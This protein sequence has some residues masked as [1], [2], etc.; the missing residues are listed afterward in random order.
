[1]IGMKY[2][3]VIRGRNFATNSEGEG[4]FEWVRGAYMQHRGTS[5]TPRFKAAD[6]FRRYVLEM[7]RDAHRAGGKRTAKRSANRAGKLKRYRIVSSDGIDLGIYRASS[8][9]AALDAMARRA[10]YR[11]Q[12]EAAHVAGPFRGYV[13]EI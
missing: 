8:E 10:G 2:K 7:T 3:Q 12:A 1:V 4:V 9:R 13:T 5:Q 6:H 11:S